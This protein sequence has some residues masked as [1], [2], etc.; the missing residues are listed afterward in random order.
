MV[1]HEEVITP[2]VRQRQLS[3]NFPMTR[4]PDIPSQFPE[5]K[6]K[7]EHQL[8]SYMEDGEQFYV[9]LFIFSIC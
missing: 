9:S 1:E 8:K 5:L 7:S 6:E 2:T 4:M 3:D